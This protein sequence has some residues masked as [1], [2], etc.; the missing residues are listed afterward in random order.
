MSIFRYSV[1][2]GAMLIMCTPESARADATLPDF[3]TAVFS[4]S[5]TINNP[6]FP[7]VPGMIS[8][9]HVEDIDPETNESTFQT[10]IVEV[11]DDTRTVAGV[12]VRVV[13]D[14]VFQDGL[15]RED[16]FDWYG[17]DDNGNVWYLGED[18]TDFEYDESGNLIGTSHPGAWEAGVA[19]AQPGHIMPAN[20][21]PGDHYYQEFYPGIAV[22]E[23]RVT[24]VNL[25]FVVPHGSYDNIVL[26]TRDT[27]ALEADTYANKFYALGV[28]PIAE[29]AYTV[30]DEELIAKVDR[31]RQAILPEFDAANFTPGAPIDNPYFPVV[32]GRVYTYE[33]EEVDGESG[34]TMEL[35]FQESHTARTSDILGIP[36][37]IVRGIEFHDGSM[38]ED[39]EFYYAQDKEGN[40]WWM[41]EHSTKFEYDD[42]GNL[43]R[44]YDDST[45]IA[46]V[47][48]AKPGYYMPGNRALGERYYEIFSPADGDIDT[49]EFASLDESISTTL[50]PL[51]DVAIVRE[52][53]AFQPEFY[54][55]KYY[56]PGVGLVRVQE[57]FDAMGN[58]RIVLE[59]TSLVPEP[60]IGS[61]IA[62]GAI[63][64]L[65]VA[66]CRHTARGVSDGIG[67]PRPPGR[68]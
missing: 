53:S 54:A 14:R 29:R 7:L 68:E 26:R 1:G 37:Q 20:P 10:I 49:M 39:S 61:T 42:A 43:L 38:F 21:Q 46:G 32:A 3:S 41:G 30:D 18:V 36:T 35:G 28:G 62:I 40:V 13:R 15:V 47:N 56:A 45:W 22:D 58:P 67:T 24:G 11:L 9:F 8:T 31:N 57:D 66:R 17:Q 34:E 6:Y 16:T 2:V 27:S 59:L 19:G 48:G 23:A 33:G 25:S 12:T 52:E 64:C 65:P 44:T 63:C 4:N 5:T 51:K 60:A 55:H 50:G